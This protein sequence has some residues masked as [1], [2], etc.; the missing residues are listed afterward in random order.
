M[1]VPHWICPLPADDLFLTGCKKPVQI[2]HLCH[3]GKTVMAVFSVMTTNLYRAL[4]GGATS[5]M[6][7]QG[8]P[9]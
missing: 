8:D 9:L 1:E 5:R 3:G 6:L 2:T 7:F 4:R